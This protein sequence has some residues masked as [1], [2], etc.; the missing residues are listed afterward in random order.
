MMKQFLMAATLVASSIGA[1]AA[2]ATPDYIYQRVEVNRVNS[3][4]FEVSS[5]NAARPSDYWCGA[6]KYAIRKLGASWRQK[7]YVVRG[8]APGEVSGRPSTI[9][10]TLDPA[11]AGLTSQSAG[12][13]TGF[14]SGANVSVQL[15]NTMCNKIP[16][17]D[18]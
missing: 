14:K 16:R 8:Y 12:F 15:A 2:V 3:A 6:S 17:N 5:R 13:G 10:F 1:H 11:A 9:Q 7:L 18:N 4:V